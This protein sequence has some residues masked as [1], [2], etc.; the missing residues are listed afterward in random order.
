MPPALQLP[1]VAVPSVQIAFL[2]VL[3]APN[4]ARSIA[5]F[6]TFVSIDVIIK[7]PV[8]A[9]KPLIIYYNLLELVQSIALV[10]VVSRRHSWH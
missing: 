7:A 6:R 5:I 10:V 8:R 3:S 4:M 9:G 2:L 1:R